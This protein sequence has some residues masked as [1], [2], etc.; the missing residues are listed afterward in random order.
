M[1]CE[2]PGVGQDHPLL[3][4]PAASGRLF[5]RVCNAQRISLMLGS[6]LGG[7][8]NLSVTLGGIPVFERQWIEGSW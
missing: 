3:S 5:Y 8:N 7:V 6:Y 2:F 1:L 4:C